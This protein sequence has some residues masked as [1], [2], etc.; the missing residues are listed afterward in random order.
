LSGTRITPVNARAASLEWRAA[1]FVLFP[2][3]LGAGFARAEVRRCAAALPAV[4]KV[5]PSIKTSASVVSTPARFRELLI[6]SLLVDSKWSGFG[7]D[8]KATRAFLS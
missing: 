1:S 8:R 4:A 3:T 5:A 7:H 6:S 2:G